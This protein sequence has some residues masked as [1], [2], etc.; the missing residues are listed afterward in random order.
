MLAEGL[1]KMAFA[2]GID[3]RRGGNNSM[4]HRPLRSVQRQLTW[5]IIRQFPDPKAAAV[6]LSGSGWTRI[7][8]D[9]V[10]LQDQPRQQSPV[11]DKV[12][13]IGYN[14]DEDEPLLKF[15]CS[16]DSEL[17]PFW[18]IKFCIFAEP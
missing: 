15:K 14:Y 4:L 2:A 18:P 16:A 8:G 5:D 9:M 13:V 7:L 1:E 17:W 11:K 12:E 3:V 10:I 6:K